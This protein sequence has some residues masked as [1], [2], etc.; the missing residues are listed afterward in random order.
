MSRNNIIIIIFVMIS[1]QALLT[2]FQIKDY[3]KVVRRLRK[4]GSLGI[5]N[6]KGK[7]SKGIIVLLCIKDKKVVQI[8]KMQGMSVFARFEDIDEFNGITIGELEEKANDCIA[9]EENVNYYRAI[10]IALEML[11]KEKIQKRK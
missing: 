9:R 2:Y 5:G 10:L 4:L 6:V 11:K 8:A 1:L 3:N 7:I